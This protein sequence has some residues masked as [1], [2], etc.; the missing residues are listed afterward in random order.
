MR[1]WDAWGLEGS[2]AYRLGSRHVLG[3]AWAF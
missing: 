1:A 2:W 3:K